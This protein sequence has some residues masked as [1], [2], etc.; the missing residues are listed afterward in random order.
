MRVGNDRCRGLMY[1]YAAP[2]SM[3][4]SSFGHTP[5]TVHSRS[6]EIEG[7]GVSRACARTM[8]VSS[9]DQK[10]GSRVL[11]PTWK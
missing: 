5:A 1:L 11:L 7:A 9:T 10:A 6:C 8:D 4:R 2:G 3:L